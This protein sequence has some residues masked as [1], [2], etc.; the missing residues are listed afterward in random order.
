MQKLA[1]GGVL[2]TSR[3]VAA[4]WPARSLLR[5]LRAEG[6]TQFQNGTWIEPGRGQDWHTRLRAAQLLR[7]RLLVSHRSAAALWRIETLT[8]A[9]RAPLEFTDPALALR[10]GGA[11]VRVHRIPLS[12]GDVAERQGLRVT[13][14]VRTV[15]DLLRT[16]PR[17]EAV[18]AVESVLTCRRV[19][20]VRRAPLTDLDAISAALLDTSHRGTTRA[21]KWLRLCEPRAGSPVETIARLHMYDAGLRPESQVELRTPSGRRIVLDFLFRQAG[22]AVE[23][24]EYAYHGTRNSHRRDVARFNQLQQCP[25]VRLVLR[26]TAEDVF[27]RPAQ[28]IQQIRTALATTAVP[29]SE[30]RP[31][32]V[33]DVQ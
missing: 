24:E 23:I 10:R 19:G 27:H 15:A 7:P 22:L 13:G 18:V 14:A 2:L 5:A 30:R 1:Q 25:E 33:D 20:G 16:E 4:G 8:P 32:L 9:T 17:D 6:W 29:R 28:V 12:D 3:A 11:G 31:H 26:F 21:L